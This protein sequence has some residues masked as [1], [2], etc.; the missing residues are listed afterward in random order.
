MAADEM[1]PGEIRR[2]FDRQDAAIREAGNRADA[3]VR[4]TNDRVAELAKSVV[5]TELWA[6]EHRSLKDDVTHLEHDMLSGFARLEA[7]AAERH[8][9]LG[10]EVRDVKTLIETEVN[11]LRTE[12]KTMRDERAKR[13]VNTWQIT[14]ALIAALAA[15]AL[16]VV[17][18]LQAGG[19]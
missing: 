19:H 4:A 1:T 16:V 2:T 12:I 8:Q 17:G 10:R 9:A 6:A 13:S 7:T 5:P 15:V 11:D 18:V 14:I 3:A